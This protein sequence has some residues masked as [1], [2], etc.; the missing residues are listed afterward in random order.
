MRMRVVH[1]LLLLVE[2]CM[3]LFSCSCRGP[4]AV[5]RAQPPRL[6]G[7]PKAVYKANGASKWIVVAAQT[8]AVATRRDLV[9]PYIVVG[10][11]AASFGTAKLKRM[12]N[13][14]R[15]EGAPFS[16][17]GMPSSPALV[18]TF[19]AAAWAAHLRNLAVG[20]GLAA[21]AGTVSL[22]RVVTGYHTWAQIGVGAALG[23]A[24]ACAW[25]AIG[26]QILSTAIIAT[27]HQY[28]AL[29]GVYLGGSAL[30]IGRKMSKWSSWSES[31]GGGD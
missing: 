8:T 11:I 21:I 12:I 19:A 3:C 15:P 20:L 5:P 24:S 26:A 16:D 10:S 18:A 25:M 22:L 9:A 14:Q 28:A 7:I 13:Q 27:R 30:F 23:T 4:A 1:V 6:D 2:S 31:S 29:Y 17:P